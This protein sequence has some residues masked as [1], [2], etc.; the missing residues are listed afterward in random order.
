MERLLQIAAQMEVRVVEGELPGRRRGMYSHSRRL[1]VIREGMSFPR[2]RSSL[3]HE[4]GHAHY[5][6]EPVTNIIAHTRQE[7]LADE[8]AAKA[9]IN[10]VEY[11]LTEAM[12]G[13]HIGV[14]ANQLDV[15]PKM[16][17]VWQG[18]ITHTTG[19]A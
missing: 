15:T 1:I 17:R 11:E 8:W 5:G 6:H 4:L 7:R 18:L 9:L 10:P 2:A 13:P 3:G 12:Y 19:A 14:I 16:I